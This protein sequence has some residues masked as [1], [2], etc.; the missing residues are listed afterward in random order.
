MALPE[1]ASDRLAALRRHFAEVSTS[2]QSSVSRQPTK[3][4]SGERPQSVA[5][6]EALP[7]MRADSDHRNPYLLA[8]TF[9]PHAVTLQLPPMRGSLTRLPLS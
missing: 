6:T 7:V 9:C 4:R 3:A 1:T 2:E 5:S 8:P